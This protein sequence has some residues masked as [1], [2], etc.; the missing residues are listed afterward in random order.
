MKK[1]TSLKKLT[2]NK[3]TLTNLNTSNLKK[4]VGGGTYT[5]PG[6]NCPATARAEC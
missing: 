1:E 3:S 2:L 4:V 6:L 5:C